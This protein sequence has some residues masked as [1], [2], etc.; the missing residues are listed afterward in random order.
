MLFDRGVCSSSTVTG[1]RICLLDDLGS[2]T[3]S[4]A[5]TG[6]WASGNANFNPSRRVRSFSA[7]VSYSES[8]NHRGFTGSDDAFVRCSGYQHHRHRR[9][10]SAGSSTIFSASDPSRLSPFLSRSSLAALDLAEPLP[11]A[12]LVSAMRPRSHSHSPSNPTTPCST[13]SDDGGNGALTMSTLM[14]DFRPSL[15]PL[16]ECEEGLIDAPHVSST[17][18]GNGR[19]TLLHPPFCTPP[20]NAD[21]TSKSDSP[22]SSSM[23]DIEILRS[24]RSEDG[25]TAATDS[26]NRKRSVASRFLHKAVKLS[27]YH[28]PRETSHQKENQNRPN[29]ITERRRSKGSLF[30]LGVNTSE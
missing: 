18:A 15:P 4:L 6:L 21:T 17:S 24:H 16:P 28:T 19:G 7:V 14:R 3:A 29:L 27:G 30:E 10:S 13:D 25:G 9:Y 2:G 26:S 22:S 11:L 5:S 8:P 12:S 1:S 20:T 23:G